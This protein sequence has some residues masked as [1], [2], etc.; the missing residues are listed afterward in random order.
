MRNV[1]RILLRETNLA[2]EAVLFVEFFPLILGR[3]ISLNILSVNE[4]LPVPK[5]RYFGKYMIQLF[6]YCYVHVSGQRHSDFER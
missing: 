6:G 2:N 1:F 5:F 3:V 4:K